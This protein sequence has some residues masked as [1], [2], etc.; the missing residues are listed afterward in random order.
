M[1]KKEH[2]FLLV[3]GYNIIHSWDELKKLAEESLEDA[4]D[5]LVEIMCDYRGQAGCEIIVVFDA[6]KV[7]GGTGNNYAY[8][9]IF[10][11][12]TKEAE[13]ADHYIERTVKEI[14][15]NYN[16]S[17]ATSDS[18]EQIIILAGGAVRVSANELHNRVNVAKESIRKK[19][20]EKAPV[21]DNLLFDGVST[22]TAEFLEEL[23]NR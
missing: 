22:E 1:R 19:F 3:D 4:R 13:T 17:V 10:V 18:L 5:R 11:V 12:F 14:S 9:N 6:H 23:R 20:I 16:V 8:K 7:R 21:K 2:S 15:R